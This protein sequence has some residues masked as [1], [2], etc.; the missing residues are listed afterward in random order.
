MPPTVLSLHLYFL[1]KERKIHVTITYILKDAQL[2]KF[3]AIKIQL[4]NLQE[5]LHISGCAQPDCQQA[6]HRPFWLVCMMRL[7]QTSEAKA[8]K[9]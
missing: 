1:Q 9:T 7:L 3:I 4:Y 8:S 2:V 6:A 5:T